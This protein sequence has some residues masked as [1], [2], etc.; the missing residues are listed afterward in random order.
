VPV[1]FINYRIDD[2]NDAVWRLRDG[3]V[4]QYGQEAVFHD[5]SK[6]QGSQDW[7]GAIRAAVKQCEVVVM[8]I[9]PQWGQIQAEPGT[10]Y[11]GLSRLFDPDDWV[12]NELLLAHEAGKLIVPVLVQNGRF[13]KPA[14]LK[15]VKLDTVVT[16]QAETVDSDRYDDE[17]PRLC[18]ILDDLSPRLKQ[19]REQQAQQRTQAQTPTGPG[20]VG[21]PT[22]PRDYLRKLQKSITDVELMG[23]KLKHASAVK[24]NMVYVPLVTARIAERETP[25]EGQD[26]AVPEVK[27]EDQQPQLLLERLGQASL[28]VSGPAGCG[29]STFCRWVAWLTCAGELPP[30]PVTSPEGYA[31]QFPEDFRGRLPVLVPLREFHESLAVRAGCAAFST[32]ELEQALLGWIGGKRPHGL[33]A[34][35]F[36]AHLQRGRLLLI[37]DG[38]DE[39]PLKRP[40]VGGQTAP[41]HSALVAGLASACEDW[42]RRGH[43]VLLTSRPY[44]LSEAEVG[45]LDLR[46]APVLPLNDE[47]QKLLVD[48]WFRCLEEDATKAAAQA[49]DLRGHVAAREDLDDL[50]GNPMLLT[51]ICVVY[52]EGKRLPQDRHDLYDRIVDH[53]LCNRFRHDEAMRKLIRYRLGFIAHGMHTADGA[54]RKR[55][56]P[57]AQVDDAE[58]ERLLL[59]CREENWYSESTVKV[60]A[61]SREELL[62]T[63]G[64]FLPQG[65]G[66]AG[67]YHLTIQ[68]FFAAE[69]LL[70]LP[71]VDLVEL[72]RTRGNVAPWRSTLNFVFGALAKSPAKAVPLLETLIGGLKQGEER[73]GLVAW[74]AIQILDKQKTPWSATTR[75]QF[76][77]FCV[78]SLTDEVSLRERHELGLAL[79]MLG[80]PRIAVDVRTSDEFVCISAGTYLVGDQRKPF[81]VK[82]QFWIGKYL[83]ANSQYRLFVDE[84]GYADERWWSPEGWAW[85]RRAKAIHSARPDYPHR[86]FT[87]PSQPVVGVSFYEAEA[88]ARWAGGRL[89]TANESEAAARGPAGLV[90]PWGDTWQ[91]GICNSRE[92]DLGCTSIVGLFPASQ[93]RDFGL[94][95]AAGNAWEWCEIDSVDQKVRDAVSRVIRGGSWYI[96]ARNVRCANRYQGPVESQ[97][98]ILGFRLVR[99]QEPS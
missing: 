94:Q 88:F 83:V 38:V 30:T 81:V 77:Q 12:L 78:Q 13:P 44:G 28:Y 95:D 58:V 91:D 4:E 10:E 56:V 82:Q 36:A 7:K 2:A 80:D 18:R 23:L 9:G 64:L 16:Q 53:V 48:C 59:A 3:L 47:L 41:V 67:F 75:D 79:G 54:G 45:R 66:R 11:E 26:A 97:S 35:D 5:K 49:E 73:L 19:L 32:H 70:Q 57:E 84:D 22:I 65:P 37:L 8:V 74:D 96:L 14:F 27:T 33:T 50:I 51:A 85:S 24:L 29:K 25:A 63:T 69:R 52:H 99:V 62:N 40:L 1:I 46:P 87:N 15:S 55:E 72:F 34:D 39:V 98:G 93:S 21:P 42:N 90:Y 20:P 86:Q 71:N 89:P 60:V 6:L 31:E 68:D 43:R 76:V 17:I 92:A 61:E